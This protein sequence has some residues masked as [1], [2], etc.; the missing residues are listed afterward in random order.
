M[1]ACPCCLSPFLPKGDNLGLFASL[2]S[3][4]PQRNE[5]NSERKNLLLLEQCDYANFG[6]VL[7]W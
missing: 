4:T 7:N 1:C 3:I 2:E 6:L 5:I